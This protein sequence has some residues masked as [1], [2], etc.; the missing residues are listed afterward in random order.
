MDDF[1]QYHG[2][3]CNLKLYI[4]WDFARFLPTS[5]MENPWQNLNIHRCRCCPPSQ[6]TPC[7][8]PNCGRTCSPGEILLQLWKIVVDIGGPSYHHMFFTYL[9]DIWLFCIVL[10]T[11]KMWQLDIFIF[12]GASNNG[13]LF[14]FAPGGLSWNFSPRS[15]RIRVES[16]RPPAESIFMMWC[17]PWM[18]FYRRW[19]ANSLFETWI[20]Q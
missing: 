9:L 19:R 14:G 13:R 8:A 20:L 2:L 17:F 18:Q 1:G 4:C 15:F 7:C 3:P 6:C 12:V 16:F 10:S 5:S 11:E